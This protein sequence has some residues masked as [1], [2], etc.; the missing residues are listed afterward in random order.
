MRDLANRIETFPS[1]VLAGMYGFKK[2]EFFEIE[3][4]SQREAPKLDLTNE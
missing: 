4:S 1:N 3:D 2:R